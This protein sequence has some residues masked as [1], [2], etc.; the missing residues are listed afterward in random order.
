MLVLDENLPAGQ[1]LLLRSWRIRFRAIGDEVAFSGAKDENLI[2]V[3]HR[4]PKPTFFSLDRDF[5]RRVWRIPVTALSGWIFDLAMKV[6]ARQA[7]D[8]ERAELDALLASKPELKPEFERLQAD[9]RIA[10]EALPL[11]DAT[12]AAAGELLAYARGRLQTKVRQTL[13]RP[14]VEKEPDRSLVWGWRWVL[15]LAAAVAM[16]VVFVIPMFRAPNEPV[17]QLAMLDTA[18]ATRGLET[19]ETALLR[20]TWS[21]ATL[22]SLTNAVALHVWETKDKPDVVKVIYD[23]SAAEV[24]VLGRW[25]GKSFEKSFLVDPDLPTALKAA[26]SFIAEQTQE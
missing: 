5:Y 6:I 16:V 4:L 22:D 2:P 17:I 12:G 10:R 15:G 24:R 26:K 9:V 14:A 19:N 20:E 1:R 3:L 13:G 21:K 23:R 8:V 18:G 11:V 7:T 25:H